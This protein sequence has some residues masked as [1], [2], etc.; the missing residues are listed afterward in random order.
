MTRVPTPTPLLGLPQEIE[1]RAKIVE[2]D[3]WK[4]ITPG[5]S[6]REPKQ[7]GAK[8]AFAQPKVLDV[9]SPCDMTPRC[10]ETTNAEFQLIMGTRAMVASSAQAAGK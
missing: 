9:F 10:L 4:R 6:L 2:M 7:L 3:V 1:C 5:M 8:A